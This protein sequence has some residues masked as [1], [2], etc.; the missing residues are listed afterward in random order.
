[1]GDLIAQQGV[2]GRGLRDHDWGRTSRFSAVGFL[3]VVGEV[4]LPP[5]AQNDIYQ[6]FKPASTNVNDLY[7]CFRI[8][9][10]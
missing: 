5:S 9:F 6:S 1:M 7:M 2:E 4:R 8:Y 3:F 10:Y